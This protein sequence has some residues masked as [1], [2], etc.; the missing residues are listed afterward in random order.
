[1]DTECQKR[2]LFEIWNF[3]NRRTRVMQWTDI[4]WNDLF[5]AFGENSFQKQVFL[6]SWRCVIFILKINELL[7]LIFRDFEVVV[8]G[9]PTKL[10]T[11]MKAPWNAHSLL[12]NVLSLLFNFYPVEF[13]LLAMFQKEY[14]FDTLYPYMSQPVFVDFIFY[15]NKCFVCKLHFWPS[16]FSTT[17]CW[18]LS[19]N[20]QGWS[21]SSLLSK[22]IEKTIST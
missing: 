17:N 5:W 10:K 1:M 7:F 6:W 2:T 22:S 14:V 20:T 4:M 18:S 9:L 12:S 21:R 3:L 8:S 16:A 15:K 19:S 13:I 11:P